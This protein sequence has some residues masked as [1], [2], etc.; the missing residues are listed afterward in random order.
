MLGFKT[1]AIAQQ[2][3]PNASICKK[4][5]DKTLNFSSILRVACP[6]NQ[7]FYLHG[8]ID[9]DTLNFSLS[10]IHYPLAGGLGFATLVSVIYFTFIWPFSW[11]PSDDLWIA[12]QTVFCVFQDINSVYQIFPDEVL[13]SGQFGIVYG[14][15]TWIWDTL[16][17]HQMH[18]VFFF[19]TKKLIF[20]F[21]Y[22]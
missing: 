14:G 22:M 8:L 15:K 10:C 19:S 3:F 20:Y 2:A 1:S 12:T 5:E 16:S 17:L 11:T 7:L 4:T 13:G 6:C 18:N 21:Q 9:L